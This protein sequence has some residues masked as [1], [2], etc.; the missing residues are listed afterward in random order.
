MDGCVDMLLS[1]ACIKP[2]CN[3]VVPTASQARQ[4]DPHLHLPSSLHQRQSWHDAVIPQ[5]GWLT[6]SNSEKPLGGGPAGP[7][8]HAE[9]QQPVGVLVQSER[10]R[11]VLDWLIAQV[12]VEA[13]EGACHALAGTRRPFPSNIAKV[14]GLS[15]P[16]TLAITPPETARRHITELRRLLNGQGR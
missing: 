9:G 1:E 12:G 16:K 10:D 6:V 15:P 14:L 8:P 11:R 5:L 13:V 7:P 3:L 2:P 4:L